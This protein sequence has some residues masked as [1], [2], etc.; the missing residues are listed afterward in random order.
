LK[1]NQV[2]VARK[3]RAKELY[4]ILVENKAEL[5]TK[6]CSVLFEY[7]GCFLSKCG[8]VQK[9]MSSQNE[10]KTEATLQEEPSNQLLKAKLIK[11]FAR[12]FE[13]VLNK[14]NTE[15][16]PTDDSHCELK[17]IEKEEDIHQNSEKTN[18][19]ELRIHSKEYS[20]ET[21]KQA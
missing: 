10:D 13:D 16:D 15:S 17:S 11:G 9:D 18:D 3:T 21:E 19:D 14:Q 4:S 6:M 20:D 5:K 2:S 1:P 7:A 12:G 8:L